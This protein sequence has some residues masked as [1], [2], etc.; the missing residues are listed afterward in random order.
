A[1]KMNI[2]Q[3]DRIQNILVRDILLFENQLSLFVPIRLSSEANGPDF[4]VEGALWS[5]INGRTRLMLHPH[6]KS[7]PREVNLHHLL[8]VM[9]YATRP[10]F[11]DD[12]HDVTISYSELPRCA[13]EHQNAGI[14]FKRG[15]VPEPWMDIEFKNGIMRIPPFIIGDDM[16]L[17][18]INL[19]AYENF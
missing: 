9:R 2:L 6:F 11:L 14:K 12:L 1:R 3:S 13:T 7:P 10:S 5:Y 8:G 4:S 15:K 18:L 17:L 19:I 16:E